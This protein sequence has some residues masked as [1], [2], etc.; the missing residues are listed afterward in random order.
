MVIK[1][2]TAYKTVSLCLVVR[3]IKLDVLFHLIQAY[4]CNT[5]AK[6]ISKEVQFPLYEIQDIDYDWLYSTYGHYY[7][8]MV[9]VFQWYW[10]QFDSFVMEF[11]GND[12]QRL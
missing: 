11:Y 1:C 8:A 2:H 6:I 4:E 7:K 9:L 3:F 12:M 5:L 10:T